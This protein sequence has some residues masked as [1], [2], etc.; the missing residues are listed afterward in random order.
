MAIDIISQT[1]LALIPSIIALLV[2]YA[3]FDN[4]LNYF[5]YFEAIF[6]AFFVG[7]NVIDLWYL[8]LVLLILAII[9]YRAIEPYK[10]G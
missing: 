3:Y 2:C 10:N 5:L 8:S 7:M 1:L 9:I 6:L 4:S